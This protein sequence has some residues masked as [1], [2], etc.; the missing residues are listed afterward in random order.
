M[1]SRTQGEKLP[2]AMQMRLDRLV[3]APGKFGKLAR[4]RLAADLSY[5]FDQAPEWTTARLLPC[6]DWSSE[7]A[8]D[9]W[10]S[11]KYSNYIGS[12]ELFAVTKPS[13]LELFGRPE[14]HLE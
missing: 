4:T 5:L 11:R 2:L 6:F 14:V 13:F 8:R 10:S 3:S 9:A 12:P 7:D 1:P